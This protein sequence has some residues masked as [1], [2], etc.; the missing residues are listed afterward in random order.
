MKTSETIA[1]LAKALSAFQ[2]EVENATKSANN[3][4]FKSKYADLA[5]V[6]NTVRPLMSKHGLA[7]AQF[8]SYE[9]NS[10][11]GI[12]SVETVLMHLSGQW[13]SCVT[14]SPVKGKV[15]SQVIGSATTYC[16][17]YPAASILGIAQEDDDGNAAS[18]KNMEKDQSKEPEKPKPIVWSETETQEW[19]SLMDKVGNHLRVQNKL[20]EL[21]EFTAKV[22]ASKNIYPPAL[23]LPQLRTRE[24]EFASQTTA[25]I[26][27]SVGAGPTALPMEGAF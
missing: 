12:V 8:P 7:L 13:M 17:R 4:F 2:G 21:D 22:T 1:E 27:K 14:S 9:G 6:L 10:E 3:P 24:K 23:L 11:Q 25:F 26:Q 20:D 19:V 16:R 15:D 18:G 5:E